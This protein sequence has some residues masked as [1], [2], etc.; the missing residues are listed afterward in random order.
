MKERTIGI[1]NTNREKK[2]FHPESYPKPS[3]RKSQALRSKPGPDN[4]Y[5]TV[6]LAAAKVDFESIAAAEEERRILDLSLLAAQEEREGETDAAGYIAAV[7]EK[8]VDL[9]TFV[10][11]EEASPLDIIYYSAELEEFE[12]TCYSGPDNQDGSKSYFR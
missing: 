2:A 3:G 4:V 10:E 12:D 11:N 6:R 8:Q 1:Q 5:V 9:A 7:E